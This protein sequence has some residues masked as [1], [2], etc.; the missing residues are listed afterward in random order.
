MSRRL[1]PAGERRGQSLAAWG[2][3]CAAVWLTL[4]GPAEVA[5]AA[6]GLVFD[7]T[8]SR[9]AELPGAM[10]TYLREL[11]IDRSLVVRT[12]Q[13]DGVVAFTLDT[14]PSDTDT[15]TLSSRQRLHVPEAQV[16]LPVSRGRV[17]RVQTVSQKEILLALMQHG[18]QTRF[19][20]AAC[21]I[22]ALREHVALRQNIVAWV[23]ELHWGWPNGHGARWNTAHWDR[24]TPKHPDHLDEALRDAMNQQPKYAIGCYTA[25]KLGFAQG[26]LDFY[27]RVLKSPAKADLVRSR[28][29][30]DGEPLVD[31]EPAATWSFE[32]DFD[33]A[34]RERPGKLLTLVHGVP[35]NN[36]VPGDWA[37]LL[38]TDPVSSQETG[39]EGSNAIYI[40]RGQFVDFYDDNRH[41]YT[42]QE[43]LDE[44]YQ[45]RHGVF[46]RSRD[47]ALIQPLKPA[48]FER[49]SAT[50][51]RGG[52]LLDFRLTPFLFGHQPL[53]DLP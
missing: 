2:A 25:A 24:G 39:Y 47:A 23:D 43:K 33:P 52:L 53:P 17:R 46:S 16:A 27:Q 40:G 37:Y 10:A 29:L 6:D 36:F 30:R 51:E 19:S 50:P 18:R 38:N 7:C 14:P 42:Y 44:V 1:R 26:V 45:W 9:R 12:Q 8:A 15:L 13:A 41:S 21:D 3:L 11:G 31:I 22:A 4:W 35:A 49:L 34:T 48:D 28:L 5:M 20:G 32:A